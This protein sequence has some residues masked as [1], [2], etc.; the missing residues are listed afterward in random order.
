[1]RLRRS[2]GFAAPASS[3]AAQRVLTWDLTSR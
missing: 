3:L 1:M 2:G